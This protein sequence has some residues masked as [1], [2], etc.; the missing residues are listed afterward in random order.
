MIFEPDRG[1]RVPIRLWARHV[2]PD[3]IRQLQRLASQDYV[4]EFV[5]AMAD[6]HVSEGVAVGSVFA[7]EH[8]LVPAALGGDLGCGMSALRI[9]VDAFG[10]DR[11]TLEIVVSRLGRAIPTG[12]ATHRGGGASRANL[13]EGLLETPLS[14]R[15]LEHT[16][17]ALLGR[18]LGTLGGGNHFL[19]LDRDADGG[20][21]L[22]VHSGSR[23]LG[24]AI[25]SHHAR[26]AEERNAHGLAGMDIRES[27]GAA[28]WQ[29]LEWAIRFARENR[30]A[31]ATRALE[32]LSDVLHREVTAADT[33]DVHHNFVAREEWFGRPL[34]VHRKGAIAAPRGDRALIPGSMGT[35]S[36]V[37]FGLANADSF[38]SCSHG[39]GRVMTRTEARR[40]IRPKAFAESMRRVVYPDA[41]ARRLV[42]EA[43]CV[44]RD[45]R[46]VLDDQ[47]DLLVRT[48]RLEP[49]A[50]LK[51]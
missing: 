43:P 40:T 49:L 50:V 14:T 9:D 46:E 32:I 8:T 33:I 34:F 31:L 18:H 48:I 13:P 21:W 47:E 28:Y 37:A 15:S 42:E 24:G 25:A 38:G 22:L 29:D 11:R 27:A 30:R 20:V 1:Q 39:A 26:A 23:G 16:R 6:A 17:E 4:V 3:T 10:L 2:G 7:T 36:Y 5:A 51:G 45:I 41:L 44:Y 12:D 19:E 35:A